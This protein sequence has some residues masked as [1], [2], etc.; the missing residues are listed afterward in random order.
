LQSPNFWNGAYSRFDSEIHGDI[1]NIATFHFLDQNL[2]KTP[3]LY[4]FVVIQELIDSGGASSLQLISF[5][6][7]TPVSKRLSKPHIDLTEALKSVSAS[8]LPASILGDEDVSKN[9]TL[10]NIY[11]SGTTGLPKAVII[12]QSR[13]V[14]WLDI[15]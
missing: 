14:A 7:R 3:F 15:T 6:D 4:L 2:I 8:P 11:T 1:G 5:D 10:V 12:K 9:D 13:L